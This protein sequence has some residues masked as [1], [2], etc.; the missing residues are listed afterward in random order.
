MGPLSRRHH[1]LSSG[2]AHC[3][4]LGDSSSS[5]CSLSFRPWG[6]VEHLGLFPQ[7]GPGQS[8]DA[9]QGLRVSEAEDCFALWQSI[10]TK[11]GI[12]ISFHSNILGEWFT[13]AP[14]IGLDLLHQLL[15]L[16]N[17][18]LFEVLN[19]CSIYVWQRKVCLHF[20]MR[21]WKIT[22]SFL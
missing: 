16:C 7:C 4:L 21:G 2:L 14:N 6:Y 13:Y 18:N 3:L 19:M 12:S 15:W 20:H 22:L 9:S 10:L 1:I 5:F 17:V 8:L 11:I